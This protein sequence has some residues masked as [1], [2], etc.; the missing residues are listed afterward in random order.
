MKSF[1]RRLKKLRVEKGLTL[2][3]MAVIFETTKATL[4]R[5]ENNIHE[6]RL[7]FI[8]EAANYFDV[9]V[10]YLTGKSDIR[11]VE[12]EDFYK[13]VEKLKNAS[14]E[15]QAEFLMKEFVKALIRT[16][17][18]KDESELDPVSAMKYLAEMFEDKKSDGV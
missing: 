4:S 7:E 5:Y 6:P 18:I 10:D 8:Q 11:N 9:S 3:E 2:D 13:D 16:G 1:G 17:K 12:D 15:D 14:K